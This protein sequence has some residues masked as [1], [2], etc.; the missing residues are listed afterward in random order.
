MGEG[1]QQTLR[2]SG[3]AERTLLNCLAVTRD[4][5]IRSDAAGMQDVKGRLQ[6]VAKMPDGRAPDDESVYMTGNRA[7][8]KLHEK[9]LVKN[10]TEVDGLSGDRYVVQAGYT[11]DDARLT[12]WVLTEAGIDEVRNL[13]V[14]YEQELAKLMR[15][16]GRENPSH[17]TE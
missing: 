14:R 4:G 7:F 8:H 15:R 1:N 3:W 10:V 17:R 11:P 5:R 9:G 16:F 6:E 2:T 12:E 13:N